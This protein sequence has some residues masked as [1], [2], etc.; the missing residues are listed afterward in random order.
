MS[1]RRE[2]IFIGDYL[3][4]VLGICTCCHIQLVLNRGVYWDGRLWYHLLS[5][6][7]FAT[8]S[9][10]LTQAGLPFPIKLFEIV[11]AFS[12]PI[13]GS[14]IVVFWAIFV[15]TY[16]IF[17]ILSN[18]F[19]ESLL[20]SLICATVFCALPLCQLTPEIS[21]MPYYVYMACFSSGNLLL[22][23]SFKDRPQNIFCLIGLLLCYISFYA[24]SFSFLQI[25]LVPVYL[26]IIRRND[27]NY[28]TLL[29]L[30]IL[31]FYSVASAPKPYGI[32]SNYNAWSVTNLLRIILPTINTSSNYVGSVIISRIVEV[33]SVPTL[34]AISLFITLIAIGIYQYYYRKKDVGDD[35]KPRDIWRLFQVVLGFITAFTITLL[36]LLPYMAVG[37]VPSLIAFQQRHASTISVMLPFLICW[38]FRLLK[39]IHFNTYK[40]MQ[41]IFVAL[42]V[43]LCV[44]SNIAY[45]EWDLDWFK[46][47]IVAEAIKE[48][49]GDLRQCQELVFIDNSDVPNKNG[50]QYAQYD[51]AAIYFEASKFEDKFVLGLQEH[52]FYRELISLGQLGKNFAQARDYSPQSN[53]SQ[54]QCVITLKLESYSHYDLNKYLKSKLADLRGQALSPQTPYKLALEVKVQS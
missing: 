15:S 33:H 20:V 27:R 26:V 37:K 46:Q 19:E 9:W 44:Q 30:I 21:I 49:M 10:A 53:Q 32:Y 35:S 22:F 52:Q 11:Q 34:T 17:T 28:W 43:T 25:L 6:D 38:M 12:D 24:Q 29:L 31:I 23:S 3:L 13:W 7:D 42:C 5:R 51:W 45:V 14:K 39:I 16:S 4:L 40:L 41:Q 2:S 8:I 50:R 54:M 1:P 47:K 48:R 36:T 18:V